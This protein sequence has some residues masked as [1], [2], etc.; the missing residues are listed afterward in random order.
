MIFMKKGDD[1][2]P[3]F[4]IYKVTECLCPKCMEVFSEKI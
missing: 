3:P 4:L 1:Y 2:S